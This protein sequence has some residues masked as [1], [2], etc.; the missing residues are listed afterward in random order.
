MPAASHLAVHFRDE[1]RR[2]GDAKVAARSTLSVVSSPVLW[3]AVTGAIGYGALVTSNVVPIRQF[4]WIM[5]L[6]TLL[7]SLLVMMISP[8][9]MI[10]P[11]RLDLPTKIGF[12]FAR[13]D[14][15]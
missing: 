13:G 2:E 7:A 12:V 11:F 4:G 5:G 1:R 14:A 8:A 15:G 6:C 9:A 3:C 10:P